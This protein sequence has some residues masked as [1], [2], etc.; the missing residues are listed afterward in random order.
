MSR[1]FKK[2]EYLSGYS[3]ETLVEWLRENV[4]PEMQLSPDYKMSDLT[5]DLG[6][7]VGGMWSDGID[8]M[9]EDA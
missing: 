8:A 9:G 7:I 2:N 5:D 3:V 6:N 4:D 1:P